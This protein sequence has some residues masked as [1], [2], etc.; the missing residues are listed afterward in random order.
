MHVS[1]GS[2]VCPT[3]GKRLQM[4]LIAAAAEKPC[5]SCLHVIHSLLHVSLQV[6]CLLCRPCLA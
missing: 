5:F 1:A 2:T 3:E 6:I 4:D